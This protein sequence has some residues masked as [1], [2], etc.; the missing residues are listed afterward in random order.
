MK[1]QFV[2]NFIATRK[3]K[4]DQNK[5]PILTYPEGWLKLVDEEY[6]EYKPMTTNSKVD[7][8][9]RSNLLDILESQKNKIRNV[10]YHEIGN[11]GS[12]WVLDRY[13]HVIISCF[14]IKPPRASSYIDTPAPYNNPKCGLI[15]IQNDDKCFEWCMKY[16]QTK[17]IKNADK[18]H[19][20]RVSVLR[21]IK[22]KYNYDDNTFPVNFDHIKHLKIII[23]YV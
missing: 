17:K 20:D 3:A 8:T 21:N 22:D 10:F 12:D 15:N 14:T 4:L 7:Q 6:W 5:N 11:L 23:R 9:V 19:A 1:I 13:K 2:L 16:H 18:L